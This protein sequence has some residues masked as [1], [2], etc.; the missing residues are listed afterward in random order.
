MA[1]VLRLLMMLNSLAA[2]PAACSEG[3]YITGYYVP[4]QSDFVTEASF[5]RTVAL[6]GTGL[7]SDGLYVNYNGR[8]IPQPLTAS[9]APIQPGV[10]AFDS[11]VFPFGT[12]FWI[13][14]AKYIGADVGGDVHGRHLD[15]FTGFGYQAGKEMNRI[16]R[17]GQQVCW[18]WAE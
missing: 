4:V 11:H 8:I 18:G 16:T 9:G 12:I 13:D 2:T 15:V 1:I 17:Q 7:R 3:W 14:G 6:E 10:V 5:Y